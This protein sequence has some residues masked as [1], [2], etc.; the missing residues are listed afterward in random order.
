MSE[1]LEELRKELEQAYIAQREIQNKRN[2]REREYADEARRKLDAEFGA[3]LQQEKEK[4]S[5]A[6]SAWRAEEDRIRLETAKDR[7]PYPEG[8]ILAEYKTLQFSSSNSMSPTAN[9]GGVEILKAGDEFVQAGFMRIS[10]G[11]VIL[12]HLKKDGTRAKRA[13]LWNDWMKERWLPEKKEAQ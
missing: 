6:L 3:R 10:V 8:T 11:D 13:E 5:A 1:K 2:E 12:R 4:Y 7:L 9:R